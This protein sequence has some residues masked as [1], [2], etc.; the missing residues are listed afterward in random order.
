MKEQNPLVSI[1]GSVGGIT[2][3]MIALVVIF[4]RD[5]AWVIAPIV[6]AMAFLGVM[7]GHFAT[8]KR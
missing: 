4:A 5:Q 6:V 8:K 7:L 1:A 2:V 3:A